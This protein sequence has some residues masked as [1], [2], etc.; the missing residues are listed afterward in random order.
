MR[1]IFDIYCKLIFPTLFRAIKVE[2]SKADEKNEGNSSN[3]PFSRSFTF[4]GLF[5]F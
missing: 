2:A 5:F 4:E 3:E 1:V